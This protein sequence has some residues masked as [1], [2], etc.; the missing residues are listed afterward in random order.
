MGI[1]PILE[2]ATMKA[3][4]SSNLLMRLETSYLIRHTKK[5]LKRWPASIV[6]VHR[7][8]NRGLD[9]GIS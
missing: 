6:I 5:A 3:Q 4:A 2:N 9:Q 8:S 7:Y 1:E